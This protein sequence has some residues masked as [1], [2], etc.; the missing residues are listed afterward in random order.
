MDR[1]LT[2]R[3]VDGKPQN[4]ASSSKKKKKEEEASSQGAASLYSRQSAPRARSSAPRARSSSSQPAIEYLDGCQL[5][6]SLNDTFTKKPKG[7]GKGGNKKVA[8]YDR[9]LRL[10]YRRGM[11]RLTIK[12]SGVEVA[13]DSNW[14][15]TVY[16]GGHNNLFMVRVHALLE[17]DSFY[18]VFGFGHELFGQRVD[19][20]VMRG[21]SETVAREHPLTSGDETSWAGLGR[22]GGGTLDNQPA[23]TRERDSPSSKLR[24]ETT[25]FSRPQGRP[26]RSGPAG[27]PPEGIL[28]TDAKKFLLDYEL[29]V[30]KTVCNANSS[31]GSVYEGGH[32]NLFMVRVHALLEND[33]FYSSRV[34]SSGLGS[35]M[36]FWS[37]RWLVPPL[38][39]LEIIFGY[40]LKL[41]GEGLLGRR[42]AGGDDKE[43]VHSTINRRHR[44]RDAV[45]ASRDATSLSRP[46]GRPARS[47]PAG[48]PPEGIDIT[49]L[50]KVDGQ[51]SNKNRAA[52]SKK[53]K[54]ASQDMASRFSHA[55]AIASAPVVATSS[56]AA[57][58]SAG[59]SHAASSSSASAPAPS[60]YR[61]S[62]ARVEPRSMPRPDKVIIDL[63]RDSSDDE[64]EKPVAKPA[65]EHPFI[66][67]NLA[68]GDSKASYWPAGARTT[69]KPGI[70][71]SLSSDSSVEESV[72][73]KKPAAKKAKPGGPRR[74]ADERMRT[75]KQA[76]R[77]RCHE[78]EEEVIVLD[79]SDEEEENALPKKPRHHPSEDSFDGDRKP[80]AK[81]PR[82]RRSNPGGD[83][84]QS[85]LA[86]ASLFDQRQGGRKP[87]ASN[88]R[89]R[90][91]NAGEDGAATEKY[92]KKI[93]R[94][95]A[96]TIE[97]NGGSSGR[98]GTLCVRDLNNDQKSA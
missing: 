61:S 52:S 98:F 73:D 53:K 49:W 72:V 80:P 93:R 35:D 56:R 87:S 43:E 58:A 1:W 62:V 96:A 66:D 95:Y 55:S 79:S 9:K 5:F 83:K 11:L 10:Q 24:I 2:S 82:H 20:S 29:E 76:A 27:A 36:N 67:E 75:K 78:D 90:K 45:E 68:A 47:G 84:E 25:S 48:A 41:S 19:K 74:D 7:S 8:R 17:N 88:R 85:A 21:K 40:A 30:D 54:E 12:K 18:S 60:W 57:R 86:F 32:N 63:S 92:A 28:V 51:P 77:K 15:G 23:V 16:E 4:K 50:T 31:N 39:A 34:P 6:Y 91:Y 71:K 42:E 37:D 3:K 46:Q 38:Q 13:N 64:N 33:S 94:D 97:E 59:A 65:K 89:K 44:E 70:G 14:L 22:Q 26:A 81:Q 69:A